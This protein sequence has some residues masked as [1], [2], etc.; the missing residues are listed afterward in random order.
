MDATP[1]K[2]MQFF[3]GDDAWRF[4]VLNM[5]GLCAFGTPMTVNLEGYLQG[6]MTAVT[7]L[8]RSLDPD[9]YFIAQRVATLRHCFNLREGINPI[10]DWKIPERALGIPPQ[11][12]GP[13]A[14]ITIDYKPN[15]YWYL[16]Q[17]DWDMKTTKPSKKKLLALGLD[18]VASDLYPPTLQK[19]AT[20]K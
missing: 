1:G 10:R 11:T 14:G 4:H 18:D 15:L 9:L 7:G 5:S 17:L 19:A 8:D 6:F 16:G 12:Q 3:G 13:N 20:V 2:H